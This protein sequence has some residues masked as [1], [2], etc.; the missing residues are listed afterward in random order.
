MIV[1]AF[2]RGD[3]VCKE[4]LA[5]EAQTLGFSTVA[6]C[7][8]SFLMHFINCIGLAKCMGSPEHLKAV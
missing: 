6:P 2:A 5:G 1:A 7:S 8:A 3:S 4:Q